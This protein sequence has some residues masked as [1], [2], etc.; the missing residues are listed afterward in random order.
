M[1][2]VQAVP[3]TEASALRE[4][5][6]EPRPYEAAVAFHAVGTGTVREIY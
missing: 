6:V 4:E 3:R 2:A 5:E 1:P